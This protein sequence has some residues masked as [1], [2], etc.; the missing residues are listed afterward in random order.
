VEDEV[1]AFNDR[2][3]GLPVPYVPFDHPKIAGINFGKQPLKLVEVAL[4]PGRKIVEADHLLAAPQ[5]DFDQVRTDEA[6]GA[7]YE[8]GG[9][10]ASQ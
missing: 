4:M 7:G 5:E 1:H 8:P 3:A 10:L 9:V 2:S 6:G